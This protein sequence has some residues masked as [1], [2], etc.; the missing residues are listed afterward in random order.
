MVIPSGWDREKPKGLPVEGYDPTSVK[1][2]LADRFLYL[3]LDLF[4]NDDTLARRVKTI[5]HDYKR[6]LNLEGRNRPEKM[7]YIAYYRVEQIAH[8]KKKDAR[9]LITADR[10]QWRGLEKDISRARKEVTR[11]FR[12]LRLSI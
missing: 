1:N 12:E 8:G 6:Q 5:V 10:T 11:L 9:S 3:K 7:K 4:V 2:L